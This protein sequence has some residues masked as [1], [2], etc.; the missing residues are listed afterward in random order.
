MPLDFLGVDVDFKP[1][2]IV[3]TPDFKVKRSHDLMIRG[4]YFYAVWDEENSIWSQDVFRCI[5]MIDKQLEEEA[6]KYKDIDPSRKVSVKYL[7]SFSNKSLVDFNKYLSNSPDNYKVLNNKIA[8]SNTKVK[9]T[10]YISTKLPYPL[11]DCDISGYDKMIS[12]L[13]SP[14]ERDKIEWAIGAVLSGDTKRIQKFIVLYGEGGTGKSTVI[15]IIKQLFEGYYAVFD[16]RGLTSSTNQ[17][18]MEVFKDNPLV[19]V[20]PDGDLSRIE[21]NTKL[22]SL[23]AHE[24]MIINEKYKR[25]YSSQTNCFLFLASNKPVMIT[26]SKSGL[27]RRL[28]D[29]SPT[30]VKLPEKEYFRIKSKIAFELPGIAKHCMERYQQL[31][32]EYYSS[33]RPVSMLMKTNTFYNFVEENYFLFKEQDGVTL[34]QAYEMYKTFCNDTK[35]DYTLPRH[36]FREELKSYFRNFEDRARIAGKQMRSYYSGFKFDKFNIFDD[37]NESFVPISLKE[38][39]SIF[40]EFCCDCPAQYA[41]QNDI[42]Q[43]KWEKVKTTLKDIDTSKVHYVKPPSNLIVIDFDLKDDNGEKSLELNVEAAS[44]WPETYTETSK[45]GKGLHLHYIYD[46]DVKELASL[47]S[48]GIEVKTF[49]GN[50]SLRRKLSLCNNVEIKHISSGLP[51]KENKMINFESLKNEKAL[52]TIIQGNLEK[53][54]HPNTKPSIDYIYKV[55]EDAYNSGMKY[56]VT[57]MRNKVLSFALGS[58]HQAE[59][60]IKKVNEMKF[61]SE[62]I[63]QNVD[64]EGPIVF[65]D[66]EVFPNLLL[67]NWK[68]QGEE[69]SCVHMINPTPAEVDEFLHYNFRLVGFN[70][71][72]YD[73]HILYARAIGYTNEQ[74]FALSQKIIN[75]SRN[76]M[77]GE[78]Y[79]LSYADVYDFAS[80]KQ[81]LKKWE[82]ELGIHHKELGY[83]WDQP[84]PE[85][86]WI[87]VSDYC[88]NDVIATE[89]TFDARHEDFVARQILS[90]LSGLTINDTTQMHTARI[91][92]G[93]DK[94]PQDKFIYTDLS[95]I[96]KGYKFENG[97]SYYKGVEVGEGGRVYAEPGMYWNV[98]VLD[99]MSMHPHSLMALNLF[100]PYTKNFKELVDARIAIKHKDYETAKGM[101]GGILAKY[102][103]DDSQAKALAYALKIVINIVYGLTS[104]SFDSKFKDPRNKDNIVAKRGALF[105]VDLQEEVQKRGYKVAHIKTDS[106]KIPGADDNIINF[107]KEFGAKFGYTFELE[108]YYDRMCLVNDAVYIARYKEP[109]KD[110]AT[111]KDIW[112]TATGAQFAHPYVFKKLFSKEEI[113]FEDLCETKSVTDAL[114]LDMNEE[115]PEGEHDYQFIG[116]VGLF[117]PIKPGCG[118]G[119]LCK[120]A[121]G[122]YNAAVGT[123]G[124]RWL[125]AEIVKLAH[126]EDDID[127]TYFEALADKA[128]ETINKFGDYDIFVDTSPLPWED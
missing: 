20:Q 95:T 62:E 91:I 107:V 89:A 68:F 71:R 60:C 102:L 75:G 78:A 64:A 13:Y 97:K 80:V 76:A 50:A 74:L 45:S 24:E 21:D 25:A 33:Y 122:K 47:Y 40:D 38:Q 48:E 69:K 7:N 85:E 10:D 77:F 56:D 112:W 35:I 2:K 124:Y 87:E 18:A 105:M 114:Y 15:D 93:N 49:L 58:T 98:P 34:E 36:K 127:M 12:T 4:G 31:G 3:L 72:R 6:S 108:D 52:R 39:K 101:L 79:N 123:K 63:S 83:K 128:K 30:G 37:N 43:T 67:V 90:E 57:D 42:P 26:D 14:E 82:I 11:E 121:N 113:L 54:Y 5:E 92:F 116:K 27:I 29:V 70:C 55:L 66:V 1:S 119:I 110:K 17:F 44:K 104:A 111:G 65:Y 84:V 59:Y 103:E 118:G 22:N 99:I 109:H 100:G 41:G 125:E 120:E 28:I 23:V 126:K 88:D 117:V 94:H 9:K 73:N 53:K 16:S 51:K 19:A 115:L 81:S 32:P 96:F 61:A 46:G 8:F 86:K 106:I